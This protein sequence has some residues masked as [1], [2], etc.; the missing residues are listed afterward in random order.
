MNLYTVV[1][2]GETYDVPASGVLS[3]LRKA[4]NLDD[5]DRAENQW[6]SLDRELKEGNTLEFKVD[7]SLKNLSQEEL[8]ALAESE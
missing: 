8:E 6:Y 1:V 2:A 7:L 4:I 5:L 3:A